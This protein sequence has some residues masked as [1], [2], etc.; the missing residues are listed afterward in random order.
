MPGEIQ[1]A[2]RRA[3]ADNQVR[4]IILEGNG[5]AFCAGYDLKVSAEKERGQVNIGTLKKFRQMP[6]VAQFISCGLK[7]TLCL[8]L[9][10]N[11]F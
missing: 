7:C 5:R 4:V 8:Q 11:V 2:V 9:Q 10:L 6:M 1:S 3:N